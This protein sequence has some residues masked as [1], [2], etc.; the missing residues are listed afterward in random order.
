MKNRRVV[1]PGGS[2][3]LGRAFAHRLVARGD[4]VV[5]LTRGRPG[6]RDGIDFVH[7]DAVASGAWIEVLDGAAAIVHMTGRRVDCRPTRANVA[8]LIRSRVHP[9]RLVGEA[10]REL[11]TPPPAWVQA[12]TLAIYGDGGDAVITETTPVSGV[13]PPQMVQVALAWE[14]AFREA[15]EGVDRAVLLRMGVAL[16][17]EADPATRRL[18]T[19]ARLGLGGAVAGGRQWMSWIALDDL[20]AGL[21]RAIDD[22]AMHGLYHLTSPAPARNR[23]VMATFRTVLGRRVGL[24]AP[25]WMTRIG[26]PLLGS[27]AELALTGRRAYPRRLVDEGFTFQHTDLQAVVRGALADDPARTDPAARVDAGGSRS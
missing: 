10:L 4:E 23:D 22:A 16:G 1:I 27:D 6:H 24:P 3:F 14:R 12:A 7:W 25:A 11:G 13:G 17:G 2:G 9:V 8:E 5:I 18:A 15:T 21:V 19:L 26:A 20:L